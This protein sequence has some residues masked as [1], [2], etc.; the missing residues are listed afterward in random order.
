MKLWWYIIFFFISFAGLAQQPSH[1]TIGSGKLQGIDVYD[2]HQ[3]QTGNYWVATDNGLYKYDGYSFQIQ[4]N[5]EM[6]SSSLFNLV[7]N[8]KGEIFC[9]NLSGQVFKIKD[10][11]MELHY[12]IPKE[13][14]NSDIEIAIRPSDDLVIFSKGIITLNEDTTI[15]SDFEGNE[16]S[17]FGKI[18]NVNG[19]IRFSSRHSNQI[20][21]LTP[22]G[23]ISATDNP[24]T[25]L[26]GE[27]LSHLIS[28]QGQLFGFGIES[29]DLWNIDDIRDKPII[30]SKK[31]GPNPTIY[32]Y[33][34]T[35]KNIWSCAN[36]QGVYM[37]D[38]NLHYTEQNGKFFPNTFI[39]TVCEDQEGNTIFGTFG[40]GLIIMPNQT[41]QDFKL[42][43]K[44]SSIEANGKDQIFIGS[45][46]GKVFQVDQF[47]E[48][49]L[50]RNNQ[51]KNVEA[52][53]AIGDDHLL[54]GEFNGVVI[55]LLNGTE[56]ILSTSSVKDVF[57]ISKDQYLIASNLYASVLDFS[58]YELK[59]INQLSKRHYC[60][61]RE[62]NSETI[63]AG[64]TSGLCLITADSN[65]IELN[66]DG[67]P[68]I[69]T[70][71]QFNRGN[72][73]IATAKYGILVYKGEELIKEL[74][75]TNGLASD[76]VNFISFLNNDLLAATQNGFNLFNP[77]LDL[78]YWINN[79]TGLQSE[80]I[81]DFCIR[82]NELWLLHNEGVQV[83][84]MNEL[85]PFNYVPKLHLH[86]IS[87][88]DSIRNPEHKI[89][90]SDQNKFQ[91][92][93]AVR[94]L[95]FQNEVQYEYRL[96]GADT[97]WQTNPYIDHVIEYQ[98]L[99]SGT[100]EFQAIARCR[101]NQSELISF[102]F[103]IRA[104]FYQ[105]WWFLLI[106]FIAILLIISYV[107]SVR[108]SRQKTNARRKN[109]LNASKLTAIQSQMNPH[110]I[111]NALNSIQDL[112]L[113]QDVENS[114][115]YIT[116]FANLVR[117]TLNYSDKDFIEFESEIKLIEL[118]LSLEKL[119]FKEDLNF[120]INNKGITDISVPPMLIQPFIE[121]ALVHGLLHKTGTKNI[122][123]TFELKD[124]L[125]CSIRDNGVGRTKSKEIN[126]RQKKDHE[127]FS[128][129]A[130]KQRFKILQ[131]NFGGSLGFEY[132]DLYEN[133]VA[134]G[135]EVILHIPFMRTF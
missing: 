61:G 129:N 28:F 56:S 125:V 9:H 50:F 1:Y 131:E 95:K 104:P 116:K 23:E 132:H 16:L 69:A 118:Y 8:N 63:Y 11:K 3:D 88:N 10:E 34:P 65:L 51:V 60:I 5:K 73:F 108:L 80:N 55:N 39:S 77:D 100:Y 54:I 36:T 76:H 103:E 120:N 107:F 32:R 44:P 135:T 86:S 90:S 92:N 37:I 52:L 99:S 96:I 27:S 7:E 13:Y 24:V 45:E 71:I 2:I 114:Y 48:V 89:Y 83:L 49:S 75:Q 68:I 78:K 53:Y 25:A 127:S 87:V 70:D 33:Y 109:E 84:D 20:F 64:T 126:D 74:N 43:D 117:S 98:S 35:S 29:F 17:A 12:Q 40:N 128:V 59:K 106:I 124:H 133:E 82:G 101:N 113:K 38:E 115:N 72:A 102:K 122:E 81:V 58:T 57:K 42:A 4:E 18:S 41:I 97:N 123:I 105:R 130:I 85:K 21:T 67:A 31:L 14:L 121:N 93:L 15:I 119:R 30:E 66:Y 6:L 62:P 46:I 111:F 112:V 26:S 22:E 19:T 110:F 47:N 91:F 79:S 94:T 134:T